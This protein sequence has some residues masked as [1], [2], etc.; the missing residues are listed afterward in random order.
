M[1][2]ENRSGAVDVSGLEA[3][4]RVTSHAAGEMRMCSLHREA[5][6]LMTS[7]ALALA[8]GPSTVSVSALV[9]SISVPTS[10]ILSLLES[11]TKGDGA[12]KEKRKLTED[13]IAAR[14]PNESNRRWLIR[15]AVMEGLM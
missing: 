3:E 15:L 8:Q 5:A 12:N 9:D 13:I 6:E 14:V 10:K 11:M 7:S 4:V 2:T 1:P